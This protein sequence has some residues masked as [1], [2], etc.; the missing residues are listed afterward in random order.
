MRLTAKAKKNLGR[1]TRRV[2]VF[3]LTAFV[4]SIL[5]GQPLWLQVAL[6]LLMIAGLI[7]A[8]KATVLDR[9]E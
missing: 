5:L 8:W 1:A 3:F 6:G 2:A 7:G 4:F 9:H